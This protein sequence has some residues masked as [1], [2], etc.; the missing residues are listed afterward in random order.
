MN[1]TERHS[2]S[3]F[4]DSVLH[5]RRRL[6]SK[7]IKI[8]YIQMKRGRSTWALLFHQSRCCWSLAIL[9]LN[10]GSELCR[11]RETTE[12]LI[13][14]CVSLGHSIGLKEQLNHSPYPQRRSCRHR[15]CHRPSWKPWSRRRWVRVRPPWS[16]AG[17]ACGHTAVGGG[18]GGD[19]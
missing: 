1:T 7:C 14:A 13:G 6:L 18:G 3:S 12:R 16:S 9:C 8:I 17:T 10:Q 15:R 4:L 19:G 2:Q 5:R 11:E